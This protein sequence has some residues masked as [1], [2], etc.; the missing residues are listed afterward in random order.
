[1]SL[2]S[3]AMLCDLSISAFSNTRKDKRATESTAR[4]E[5]ADLDAVSVSKNILPPATLK[6]FTSLIQKIRSDTFYKM[7]LPWGEN[8]G[9]RICPSRIYS[10][11]ESALIQGRNDLQALVSTKLAPSLPS[12]LADVP[13]RLGAMYDPRQVPTEQTILSSFS[14]S[15]EFMPIP[16]SGD[17]RVEIAESEVQRLAAD[18]QHAKMK[19]EQ[20]ATRDIWERACAAISHLAERLAARDESEA[21][22]EGTRKSPIRESTLDKLLELS[23]LIPRL[24]VLEDPAVDLLASDMRTKLCKYSAYQLKELPSARVEVM[25]EATRLIDLMSGRLA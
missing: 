10:E 12:L 23:D 21:G 13:R 22:P 7:T 20:L 18:Y 8:G 4:Q 9:P 19:R 16:E 6:P 14:I 3:K 24:N 25:D 15:W 2:T 11:L 1:M 17:F 5:G